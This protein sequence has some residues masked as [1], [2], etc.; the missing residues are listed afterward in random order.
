MVSPFLG[1]LLLA[2]VLYRR[3]I[4]KLDLADQKVSI[5]VSAIFIVWGLF[6]WW[7]EFYQIPHSHKNQESFG[8]LN[9]V[10]VYDR[11]V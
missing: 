9:A 5:I 11:Q 6:A 1:G 3:Y 7:T 10:T 4:K 8:S 2:R